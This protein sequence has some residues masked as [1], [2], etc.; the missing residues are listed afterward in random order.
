MVLTEVLPGAKFTNACELP[1]D[2]LTATAESAYR[3]VAL[4]EYP[5]WAAPAVAIRWFAAPGKLLRMDGQGSYCWL[6]AAGQ[7]LTDLESICAAV[8]DPGS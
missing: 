4:P 2:G 5:L 3:Q 6:W 8:P 1:G 7:A